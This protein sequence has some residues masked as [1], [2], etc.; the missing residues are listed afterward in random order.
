MSVTLLPI[1]KR[2]CSGC[3][4]GYLGQGGVFCRFFR[5]DI[6]DETVAQECEEWTPVP[7]GPVRVRIIGGPG[8][9]LAPAP[10][11]EALNDRRKPP[12]LDE[13]G[14]EAACER[15]L[16]RS[17]STLWGEAF[18]IKSQAGRKEA[19]AWLARQLRDVA[20]VYSEE[21]SDADDPD[22]HAL[23]AGAL[24]AA[25]RDRQGDGPASAA[26]SPQGEPGGEQGQVLAPAGPEET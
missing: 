15:L 11:L 16:E 13:A 25:E 12:G 9:E 22:Q 20:A 26:H 19:A 14:L 21:E 6:F 8:P 24:P 1:A 17:H 7:V 2:L 5:E 18:E 4:H 3:E 23:A 10:G